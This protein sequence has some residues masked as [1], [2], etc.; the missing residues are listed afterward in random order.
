LAKHNK[1]LSHVQNDLVLTRQEV[2]DARAESNH[3]RKLMKQA[4]AQSAASQ[5]ESN[6]FRELPRPLQI[7]APT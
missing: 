7:R 2:A 3:F 6:H 4:Q 5:V 1:A